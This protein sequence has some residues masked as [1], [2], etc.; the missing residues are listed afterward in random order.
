MPALCVAVVTLADGSQVVA[1]DAT[2]AQGLVLVDQGTYSTMVMNPLMIPMD[3][4][5]V[6][7]LATVGLFVAAWSG[8]Q[9][10]RAIE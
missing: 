4:A 10:R 5:P 2:C 1:P 3:Q 9:A 7:M 6:V 8:K